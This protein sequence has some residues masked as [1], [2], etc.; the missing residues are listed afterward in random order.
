MGRYQD[1]HTIEPTRLF[2]T[3]ATPFDPFFPSV[4]L[5]INGVLALPRLEGFYWDI[6]VLCAA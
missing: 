5:S 4:D 3:K 2:G 6:A 1:L